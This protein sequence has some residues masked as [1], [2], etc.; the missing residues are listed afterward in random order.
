MLISTT[1][2]AIYIYLS[3]C[4]ILLLVI[5]C[6]LRKMSK[7]RSNILYNSKWDSRSRPSILVGACLLGVVFWGSS[8]AFRGRQAACKLV[9]F[10]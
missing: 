8:L 6:L 1:C 4:C 7:K 5:N 9:F 2:V 3:N 10:A